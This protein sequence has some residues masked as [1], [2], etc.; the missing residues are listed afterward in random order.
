MITFWAI[1]SFLN[2]LYLFSFFEVNKNT[3]RI[4]AFLTVLLFIS[5][6]ILAAPITL[7]LIIG[8]EIYESFSK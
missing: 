7:F 3:D 4:D 8:W 6:C 5:I 2:I 1:C